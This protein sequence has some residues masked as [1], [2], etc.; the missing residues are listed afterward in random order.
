MR[1]VLVGAGVGV[2]IGDGVEVSV[3]TGV[4]HG[5]GVSSCSFFVDVCASG[6]I[7]LSALLLAYPRDGTP[8]T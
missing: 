4:G 5:A 6:L 7:G 8:L 2:S 3:E 1:S